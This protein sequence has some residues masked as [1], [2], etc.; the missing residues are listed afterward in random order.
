[1]THN[2]ETTTIKTK[3]IIASVALIF[4]LIWALSGEAGIK[5]VAVTAAFACFLK[6]GIDLEMSS[7]AGGGH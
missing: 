7:N 4:C 3:F 6:Y 2:E 5:I 1:M